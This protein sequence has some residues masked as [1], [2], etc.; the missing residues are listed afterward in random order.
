MPIVTRGPC[1]DDFDV[2]MPRLGVHRSNNA[3]DSS[4]S[5]YDI[6]SAFISLRHATAVG[7]VKRQCER[8]EVTL[9]A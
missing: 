4:S 8:A 5:S 6:L 7:L 3:S 2:K 1:L 9:I